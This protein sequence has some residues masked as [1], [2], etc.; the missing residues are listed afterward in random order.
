[1]SIVLCQLIRVE[2]CFCRPIRDENWFVS[3]NQR[4]SLSCVNQSEMSIVLCQ[5]IRV[6]HC[7]C[8]PIRDEYWFVSTNQRWSLSCVNQSEMSIYLNHERDILKSW[9]LPSP[10]LVPQSQLQTQDLRPVD[11]WTLCTLDSPSLPPPVVTGQYSDNFENLRIW[12]LFTLSQYLVRIL[13]RAWV[14][15]TVVNSAS[16]LSNISL[17]TSVT[18]S[19]ISRPTAAP[20][21]S[22]TN[23]RSV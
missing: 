10:F 9:L 16:R 12:D 21:T 20:V 4:W 5:L 18:V 2:H 11:C 23:Q 22:L 3:T 1:M 14:L 13:N 7:F 8:R 19:G 15:K 6:E 17:S